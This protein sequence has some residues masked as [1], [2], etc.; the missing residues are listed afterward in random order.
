MFFAQVRKTIHETGPRRRMRPLSSKARSNQACLR[1]GS[2][3]ETFLTS[4]GVAGRR[5]EG[6][7]MVTVTH[8]E[9]DFP[10]TFEDVFFVQ[11]LSL[12]LKPAFGV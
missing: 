11:N 5:E 10:F 6:Y 2:A 9:R 7:R 4:E 8:P 3:P 12:P 1:A